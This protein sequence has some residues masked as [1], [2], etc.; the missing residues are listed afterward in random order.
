ME[1]IQTNRRLNRS[2]DIQVALS[3]QLA[4]TA[5]RAKFES[6]VLAD[7]LGLVVAA[8]G[9]KSMCE[10]MAAVSPMLASNKRSWHGSVKTNK[11]QVRL[12]IA[13]VSVGK[14][15]LYLCACNGDEAGITRELFN[16]GQGIS[17]ILA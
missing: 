17:R 11:G 5:E 2:E 8:A 13:P 14:M 1:P 3:F 7:D 12:S 10:Q 4:A 16:G 15:K 9:R 6:I